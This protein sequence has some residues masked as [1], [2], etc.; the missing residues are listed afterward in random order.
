M[1]SEDLDELVP[2]AGERLKSSHVHERHDPNTIGAFPTA[3]V[4]D[5]LQ[6]ATLTRTPS[7]EL[8]R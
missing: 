3:A 2:L 5:C 6:G 4:R 7:A 1:T 8:Y